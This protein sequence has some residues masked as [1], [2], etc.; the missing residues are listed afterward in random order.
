MSTHPKKKKKRHSNQFHGINSPTTPLLVLFFFFI[1]FY[2]FYVNCAITRCRSALQSNVVRSFVGR[3][4]G[5]TGEEVAVAVAVA[6]CWWYFVGPQNPNRKKK[7]R[8]DH[9]RFRFPEIS[10]TFRSRTRRV[11]AHWTLVGA[12]LFWSCRLMTCIWHNVTM[13]LF[14][15]VARGNKSCLIVET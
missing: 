3:G 8:S 9:S 6:D 2:N 4:G 7:L 5:G 14:S 11:Y 10:P 12:G 15:P 13:M 1:F